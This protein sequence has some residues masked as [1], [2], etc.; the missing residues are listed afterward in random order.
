MRRAL[1]LLAVLL[2]AGAQANTPDPV[3]PD[4]DA[5]LNDAP[6]PWVGSSMPTLRA[7]P[8]YHMTEMIQAEPGL[9]RRLL[10]RMPQ[11]SS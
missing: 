2:F 1:S 4:P 10:G 7:G 3:R 11:A 5:P 9:S 6:D 8:P